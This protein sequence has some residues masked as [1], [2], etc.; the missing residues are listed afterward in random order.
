L[1]NITLSKMI[2]IKT[3]VKNTIVVSKIELHQTY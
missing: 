1:P 3:I 2:A